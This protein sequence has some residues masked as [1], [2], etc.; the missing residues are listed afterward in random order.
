M[1]EFVDAIRQ[2]TTAHLRRRYRDI[3]VLLIDDMISTG[4][5]IAEAARICRDHGASSVRIAATHGVLCGPAR[6]R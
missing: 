3:D 5:S 6:E 2:N 1:N 4:G